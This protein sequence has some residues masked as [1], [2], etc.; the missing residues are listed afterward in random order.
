MS[1]QR[2]FLDYLATPRGTTSLL[3]VALCGLVLAFFVGRTY[4]D[5]ARVYSLDFGQAEWIEASKPSPSNYFRKDIYLSAIVEQAWVQIAATD[6]YMFYVNGHL[7]DDRSFIGINASGL[8]DLKTVLK[9]GKNALAI[10]V[11][12]RS[13]PGSAQII[14]RGFYALQG[15]PKQE[16]YSDTTWRA[17]NTQD[18]I[19]GSYTWN[20]TDLEDSFWAYAKKGSVDGRFRE[21]DAVNYDLRLLESKPEAKWIGP[22]HGAPFEASFSCN[23]QVP[24]DRKETWLQI[25]ATGDYDVSINGQL[26]ASQPF[27]TQLKDTPVP[28]ESFGTE[29]R[30]DGIMTEPALKSRVQKPRIESGVENSPLPQPF[31]TQPLLLAF[32]VRRWLHTGENTLLIRVRSQ[33]Q[34]AMLLAEGFTVRGDGTLQRFKTDNTWNALSSNAAKEPAVILAEYGAAPWGELEQKLASPGVTPAY[35][36]QMVSRWGLVFVVAEAVFLLT[37]VLVGSLASALIKYSAE[38]LWTFDAVFHVCVLALILACWLLTFDVRFPTNWC[39]KPQVVLGFVALLLVGKLLLFLPRKAKR[40]SAEIAEA[41]QR[42]WWLRRYGKVFVLI[43]IVLLGF[44][45]RLHE[46]SRVSLDVDEMNVIT[47]SKGVQKRG[48]PSIVVGPFE[49]EVTTYELISYPLAAARQVLGENEIAYRTPALIWSTLTIAFIGIAGYRM[50]SWRVGLVAALIYA[51]FPAGLWWGRNAFWPSQEQFFAL[52]SIWCFYEAAARPGSLRHGFLT[53]ASIAFPLAY[54]SWEGAGFL[55]P[56]LFV[57]MFVL[58]WGEYAWMKD[59]H[60]WRCCVFMA[61]VVLIQLTHR[62]VAATPPYLQ[63]GNS[64]AEVTTPELVPLDLTKFA[65]FFYFYWLLFAENYIL[66]TLVALLGIAFCWRD[67]SIRYLFVLTGG[68]IACYTEFLPA[69]AVRYSYGY[70][71]MLILLAVGIMFKL[72]DAIIGLKESWLRWCG[73]AALLTLFVLST[74]GFVLK[75]YRLA[76][77]PTKPFYGERMGLYRDDSRAPARFLAEHVR[78]G[79]GLVITIPTLFEY[80]SHLTGDY[81]INTMFDNRIT[82]DGAL[83]SPSFIDKYR[84]YPTIRGIEELQ[85]VRSRYKRL[86]VVRGGGGHTN[87]AVEQYFA[88]NAKEVFE[89]YGVKVDLIGGERDVSP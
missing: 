24:G 66:M 37:W 80:Y 59:W 72:L 8:Y 69:Y 50:M 56:V 82:Y 15:S 60:L 40:P 23:V 46:I 58:K 75:S 17:S 42:Y 68:L 81:S 20:A 25:A 74:N 63:T 55:L 65:P 77:S 87:P 22:A 79:D 21:I 89:S 62:Q 52:L 27:S 3:I 35:D 61:F 16:F 6:R 31:S 36:L 54:L 7:L 73:A 39:F 84:G 14:V 85:D 86:W 51:T 47:M 26:V 57:C 83:D 28:A 29:L 2:R 30:T 1:K 34:A 71:A 11:N 13:Y 33:T 43:G 44:G 9:P 5:P 4:L 10:A 45:L 18:G 38:S 48:Y 53:V 12:R 67:R 32:E 41:L 49:R 76:S 19:V 70:Q 64:L 78:P 88:L